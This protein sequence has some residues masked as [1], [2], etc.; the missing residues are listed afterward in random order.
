VRSATNEAEDSL[1]QWKGLLWAVV[2]GIPFVNVFSGCTFPADHT[3]HPGD[4]PRTSALFCDI[5]ATRRC[6]TEDERRFGIDVAAP[7]EDGFWV[8][9]ASNVGLD[10]SSV[11]LAACGGQPQAVFYRHAFPDGSPVCVNPNTVP[12]LAY[13]SA[14]IACQAWCDTLGLI[15]TDGNKYRCQDI[16]WRSNG[17]P[18]AAAMP[19]AC[20]DAGT[21][22][23]D[24]DDPRKG[25]TTPVVWPLATAVGVT[26]SGSNLTK[27]VDTGWGSEGL[28]FASG[29]ISA[30]HLDSGDGAV[31]VTVAESDSLRIFGLGNGTGSTTI[32]DIEYGF[33]MTAKGTLLVFERGV[34]QGPPMTVAGSY[35]PGDELEVAIQGG[36]V[37]YK[38]WRKN[39]IPHTVVLFTSSQAP[40]YPLVV[41]TAF[42]F[43]GATIKNAAVS[44]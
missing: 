1:R 13:P 14:N 18:F 28:A 23:A 29:A 35:G 41:E 12:S 19:G 5:E 20:T 43:N 21:L 24:F 44:F 32:E 30:Q 40:T 17:V 10:Y 26:V 25:P 37:V 6:S 7:F 33:L 4:V 11:A 2:A 36:V 39:F 38:Q 9:K 22:R 15:D 3:F 42:N 8:G 16:A 27:N 34:R 31:M